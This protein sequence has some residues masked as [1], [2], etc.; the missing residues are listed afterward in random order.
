[1]KD[2]ANFNGLFGSTRLF[3]EA[4]TNF[5]YLRLRLPF[6]K[7]EQDK[8]ELCAKCYANL[9]QM[10]IYIRNMKRAG[11]SC[12]VY[13]DDEYLDNA[14]SEIDKYFFGISDK[15]SEEAGHKVSE[16]SLHNDALYKY[17]ELIK[18]WSSRNNVVDLYYEFVEKIS[19]A[20]KDERLLAEKLEDASSDFQ[21]LY[22]EVKDLQKKYIFKQDDCN[23]EN[24]I[25]ERSG[26]KEYHVSIQKIIDEIL[27]NAKENLYENHDK[28]KYEDIRESEFRF[29]ET[30]DLLAKMFSQISE[31]FASMIILAKKEGWVDW[32]PR[33]GKM[34]GNY[35]NCIYNTG[36]SMIVT[37]FRGS[38]EDVCK[39]AH[40][41]AHAYHGWLLHKVPYFDAEI[42]LPD[43][44]IFAICCENYIASKIMRQWQAK[45]RI[46]KSMCHNISSLLMGKEALKVEK[47]QNLCNS[48]YT[49]VCAIANSAI[50]YITAY[51]WMFKIYNYFVSQPFYESYYLLGQLLYII[52]M[53]QKHD[54]G[55]QF[56]Q[57]FEQAVVKRDRY[58]FCD[59][60]IGLSTEEQVKIINEFW[61]NNG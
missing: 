1:M 20:D 51:D 36:Q 2:N 31:N 21:R 27:D 42:V 5:E 24:V 58:K 30:M 11:L 3:D 35:T 12:N 13:I 16:E 37:T 49:K 7:S 61:F 44:E 9:E 59:A 14:Y 45:Y 50:N 23:Y 25:D 40:E 17:S 15:D 41:L 53:W 52:K 4:K 28:L 56:L 47:R 32:Q 18:Y 57:C 22:Y 43:S 34:K 46:K 29:D 8:D 33:E 48:Y 38:A 60:T 39:L 54:D 26:A 10:D 55:V 6:L 19:L